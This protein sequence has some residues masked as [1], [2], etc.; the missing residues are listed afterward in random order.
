MK[1]HNTEYQANDLEIGVQYE[2]G[3]LVPDG[4][5]LPRRDPTG[6]HYVPST[7][8][9]ARLPHAW[10]QRGGQALST[11][12]LVP[13]DGFVLLTGLADSPWAD[14]AALAAEAFGIR[15]DVVPITDTGDV[16]DHRHEWRRIREVGDHGALLVRPDQIIAWRATE[17]HAD[18]AAQL[19]AVL[20]AV[21][22]KSKAAA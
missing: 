8:P 3:A 11:Q 20:R 10:L 6:R 17:A 5:P 13:R 15:I 16:K 9:G 7:R 18:P 14:A 21:L 12:D 1:L 22:R 4:T 19:Q 2:H